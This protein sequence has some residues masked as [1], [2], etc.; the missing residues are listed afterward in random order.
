MTLQQVIEGKVRQAFV[1]DHLGLENESHMHAGPALESHFK[2]VLVASAFNDMSRV[3][4]HQ[5]V[6]KVLADEM[7]QFHALALH[8]FT[9]KEWAEAQAVPA[10]PL[11]AGGK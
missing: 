2:L 6:Y 3:K 11:C 9:P 7:Q 1:P 5:A 10:S 8:T 4:R